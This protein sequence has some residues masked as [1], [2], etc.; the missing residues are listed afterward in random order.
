MRSVPSLCQSTFYSPYGFESAAGR[1]S[2]G[3]EW[4]PSFPQLIFHTQVDTA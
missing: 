3:W 1:I 4:A 2:P